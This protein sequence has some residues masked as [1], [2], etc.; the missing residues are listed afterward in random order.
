MLIVFYRTLLRIYGLYHCLN[1][2]TEEKGRGCAILIR[3]LIPTHNIDIMKKNRKH[4]PHLTNGPAKLVQALN[5]PAKL[6]GSLINK[7]NLLISS[8]K[9]TPHKLIASTRIG[10]SKGQDKNWRFYF[11]C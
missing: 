3:S 6:N 7:K 5:I 1:I 9:K 2:S 4:S 10:I 11:N 8:E